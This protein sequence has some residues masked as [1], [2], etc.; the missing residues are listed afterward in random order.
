MTIE[1]KKLIVANLEKKFN[2]YPFSRQLLKKLIKANELTPPPATD[3][4]LIS[5][6]DKQ[7]QENEASL[8]TT[9]IYRRADIRRRERQRGGRH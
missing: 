4:Q 7:P 5:N 1:Y 6:P 9:D 8:N 2:R 3:P